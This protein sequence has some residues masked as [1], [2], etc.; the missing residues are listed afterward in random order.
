VSP[1]SVARGA[2]WLVLVG[3]RRRRRVVH[4]RLGVRGPRDHA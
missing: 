1:T 2:S 4:V 3:P